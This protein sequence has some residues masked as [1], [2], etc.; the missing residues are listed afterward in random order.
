MMTNGT[1]P[2]ERRE[3]TCEY[4]VGSFLRGTRHPTCPGAQTALKAVESPQNSK[5]ADHATR[6][7]LYDEHHSLS[8]HKDN[9]HH[10]Q[11]PP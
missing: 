11:L 8:N 2:G 9:Y 6:A 10:H 3:G 1:A 4:V 7:L 5:I